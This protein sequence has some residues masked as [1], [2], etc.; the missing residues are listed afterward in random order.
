[1]WPVD[2]AAHAFR[3]PVISAGLLEITIQSLLNDSPMTLVGDDK[4][5][6]IQLEP[7]LHG[8]T[9]HFCHQSAGCGELG[10]IEPLSLSDLDQLVRGLSGILAASAADMA[11]NSAAT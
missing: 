5:V 1:M 9:V 4:A 11:M 3:E 7:V 6:Q 8:G 2:K 10:S